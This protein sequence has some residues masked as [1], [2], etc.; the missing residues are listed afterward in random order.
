MA[1]CKNKSLIGIFVTALLVTVAPQ[2]IAKSVQQLIEQFGH[3]KQL[4]LDPQTPSVQQAQACEER[5]G[6]YEELVEL[7]YTYGC[8]ES[9]N[10][11][12]FWRNDCASSVPDSKKIISIPLSKVTGFNCL[13]P[14]NIRTVF[15]FSPLF[16]VKSSIVAEFGD[17]RKCNFSLQLNQEQWDCYYKVSDRLNNL[18]AFEEH[19][20]F[21]HYSR[22]IIAFR[23][24]YE[25]IQLRLTFVVRQN[26]DEVLEHYVENHMDSYRFSQ[27]ES[28][29]FF[30]KLG[31][32]LRDVCSIASLD[33]NSFRNYVIE[34]EKR[35][36]EE[37]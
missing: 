24:Y 18:K 1:S 37:Q 34:Q 28:D 15:N 21:F 8:D 19:N 12:K 14:E 22:A 25:W 10:S 2:A 5:E 4:C 20:K 32:E 9:D 6:I 23:Q 33:D 35:I 13:N 26:G 31:K 27:Q 30:S 11:E 29:G 3:T 36:E 16:E 17:Q 7:G